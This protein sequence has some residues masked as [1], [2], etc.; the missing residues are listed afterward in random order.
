MAEFSDFTKLVL[1]R[2]ESNPDEFCTLHSGYSRWHGLTRGLEALARGDT[3]NKDYGILWALAEEERTAL[4]ET[5]RELYLKELHKDMLKNIVSGDDKPQIDP[6][7]YTYS[8]D[9]NPIKGSVLRGN[10]TNT[11]L[12]SSQMVKQA[13]GVL[14]QEVGK[15]YTTG[16]VDTRAVF[17]NVA[18]KG[19]GQPVK[20]DPKYDPKFEKVV[21][22]ASQV[23]V[24][25]H[26]GLSPAEYWAQLKKLEE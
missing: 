16:A 23:S 19:E 5:Y 24:A 10:T 15:Q 20:Y 21:L 4:L 18:V 17:G 22:T 9:I 8:N 2:M 1:D 3:H 6:R 14:A 12:T 26:L 7:T 11:L 13:Q 25:K